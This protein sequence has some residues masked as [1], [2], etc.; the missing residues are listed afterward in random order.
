MSGAGVSA[1]AYPG[2][3]FTDWFLPSKEELNAMYGYKGSIVDTAKYGFA[4]NSYWSSS[5][6]DTS[7]AWTQSWLNS[8]QSDFG[9][10]DE[11][12]VRPIRSF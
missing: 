2:G 12:L 7:R 1:R 8:F 5:Q 6:F 9:K 3:G 4:T 10:S 11:L